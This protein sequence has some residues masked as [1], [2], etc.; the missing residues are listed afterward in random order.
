MHDAFAVRGV[1]RV[2]HLN[3][4]IQQAIQFHRRPGDHVL[5]RAAIQEFHGDERFSI[6]LAD[7]VNRADVGVIQRGS[8]LRFSLKARESL[9]VFRH[10]IGQEFQRN[11]TVQPRVLSLVDDTHASA[12]EAFHNAVMRKCLFKQRVVGG[13]AQHILGRAISQV[14]EQHG[15]NCVRWTNYCN[16]MRYRFRRVLWR[17]KA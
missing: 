4:Q 3:R 8:G 11:E 5:Q 12:A 10:I 6:R 16:G 13:H 7:V 9:R 14:N 17:V 2:R 1:Q 15:L